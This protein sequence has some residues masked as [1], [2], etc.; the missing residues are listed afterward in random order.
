[1]K[2]LNFIVRILIYLCIL[3]PLIISLIENSHC[4]TDTSGM[5][6]MTGALFLVGGIMMAFAILIIYAVIRIFVRSSNTLNVQSHNSS[7]YGTMN[8]LKISATL[9]VLISVHFFLPEFF[10]IFRRTGDYIDIIL[11]IILAIL[12][13]ILQFRVF[14]KTV[15]LSYYMTLCAC[16]LMGISLFTEYIS[17]IELFYTILYTLYS[18]SAILP[19][20]IVLL[21]AIVVNIIALRTKQNNAV[22]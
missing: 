7:P 8:K 15:L 19:I 14:N 3:I 4:D 18:L 13:A 5:C 21:A 1:M 2:K 9:C 20:K 11:F 6:G 16:I 17:S 10:P 22:V 12:Q